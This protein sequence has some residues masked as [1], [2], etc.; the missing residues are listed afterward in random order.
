[1]TQAGII[2]DIGIGARA[3]EGVDV[4]NNFSGLGEAGIV[5]LELVWGHGFELI[6]HP[7]DK[8]LNGAD[9]GAHG[10]NGGISTGEVRNAGF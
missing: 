4:G 1:M 8:S 7:I 9:L 6:G 3:T 2:V 10:I 5:F